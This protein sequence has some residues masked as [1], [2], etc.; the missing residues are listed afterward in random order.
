MVVPVLLPCK[1]LVA[2]LA[3]SAVR[4]D[5]TGLVE[6]S[7]GLS[8]ANCWQSCILFRVRASADVAVPLLLVLAN[9]GAA[10]VYAGEVRRTGPAQLVRGA[11]L[12]GFLLCC[13]GRLRLVVRLKLAFIFFLFNRKYTQKPD[14]NAV[15]TT[16]KNT[17]FA[18]IRISNSYSQLY[19]HN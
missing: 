1:H 10:L 3:L 5:Q 14:Q 17:D 12:P 15:L 9:D 4:S 6:L 19:M 16:T 18:G 7:L 2:K 13:H 11:W 8:R